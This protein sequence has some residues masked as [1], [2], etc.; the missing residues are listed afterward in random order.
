MPIESKFLTD[1][2]SSELD[3]EAKVKKIIAEHE[4]DTAGLK[5]NRD[6]ILQEKGEI[7]KK[8][9]AFNE[10]ENGY[11]EQIKTLS[12]QIK[13]AG[14]EETKAFYEAEKARL[15]EEHDKLKIA[16]ETERDQ[17]RDEAIQF[18]KTNEFEKAVKDLKVQIRPEVQED[19]RDLFYT[20]NQFDRKVID[21]IPRFLNKEARTVQD[22]LGAYLET[23]AGKFYLAN[24]NTGGGASGAKSTQVPGGKTMK[25]ADFESLSP[26][27][28]N[29]VVTVDKVS[30]VD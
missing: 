25:R 20:R 13:K 16:L 23:D 1:V 18:Y 29:K 26:D 28:Q 3:V 19:L 27:E 15:I 5:L 8:L 17:Y 24:G 14:S 10:Q 22:A 6:E 30:I 9:K 7:E 2:L 21:G 4:A 12:E 11:K